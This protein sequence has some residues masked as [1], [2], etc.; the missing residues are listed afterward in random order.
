[1]CG[2]EECDTSRVSRAFVKEDTEGAPLVPRRAPLPEGTR[3]YVTPRGLR[4]LRAELDGLLAELSAREGR[5]GSS[6]SDLLAVRARI[7]ELEARLASA[8]LVD[9]AQGAL[10]IVRFGARVAVRFADGA[11]RAYRI[12]G[13]DEA[14]AAEGRLAFVAP[15]ARALIGKRAGD[16]VS[17]RTPRGEDE[18]ELLSLDFGED[19]E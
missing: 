15:L 16:V 7:A 11:E 10:D 8:E 1:M 13:V 3:N 14:N 6:A 5:S 9:P 18:V 19:T 12:V 4:L 2:D 17:W